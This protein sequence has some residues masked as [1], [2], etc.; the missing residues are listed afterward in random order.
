MPKLF[1]PLLAAAIETE[2]DYDKL[3]YPL[4]ASPKIDGI[5]VLCDPKL[6]PVTRSLKPIPNKYI[7]EYL[8]DPMFHYFDGE[9]VA[10]RNF[11]LDCGFNASQSAVMSQAGTPEFSYLVFDSFAMHEMKCPYT[12]RQQDMWNQLAKYNH[13]NVYGL[14]TLIINSRVH[15]DKYE[16]Q[17]VSQGFE[18]IMLRNPAGH[19]KCGRSTL[20]EGILLKLKRF[21]D[22]EAEVI[23]MEYLERNMNEAFKDERGYQK[24]SA[25]QANKIQ[26]MTMMGKLHC[27]AIN[28]HFAGVEFDIGSGFDEAER[29]EICHMHE[30]GQL[31][32]KVLTF[33]YQHHGS[34]N[35]PRTPIFKAFRENIND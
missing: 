35:A 33:K 14:E 26:D 1:K 25:H 31:V 12:T 7:R 6:G 27:R 30:T 17:M 24:R 34:K 15:L 9:I 32:N 28:G 21:Q 23:G 19:Y 29:R 3:Q 18:G 13:T 8:S 4:I 22:A 10:D 5:R 2:A 16:E 20:N 11:G